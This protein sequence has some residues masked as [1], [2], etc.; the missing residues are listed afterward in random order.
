M[1]LTV[2]QCCVGLELTGRST[3]ARDAVAHDR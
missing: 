2:L 1:W 3:E